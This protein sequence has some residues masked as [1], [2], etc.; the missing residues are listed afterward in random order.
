MLTSKETMGSS[1]QTTKSTATDRPLQWQEDPLKY[2][3]GQAED[4]YKQQSS[5]G[6]PDFNTYT[7]LNNVEYGA[8]NSTLGDSQKQAQT[9]S[10][11]TNLGSALAGS[12]ALSGAGLLGQY[13]SNAASGAAGNFQ[14]GTTAASDALLGGLGSTAGTT[15][16]S[17]T[18]A[19][20][21]ANTD[22]TQ[23]NATDAAAYANSSG[24]QNA[25]KD[26]LA[27]SDDLYQRTAVP[28]L[29]AAA[30]AGGNLNS[31]RAGA[32]QAI[33]DAMQEKN[34]QATASNM[35]NQ[36]FNQGLST[37]ESGRQANLQGLLG[38]SGQGNSALSLALQGQQAANDQTNTNNALQAT[39]NSQLGQAGSSLVG[40]AQTGSSLASDGMNMNTSANN[41][42]LSIG[43][44]LQSDKQSQKDAALNA[45][46]QGK[47]YDWDLLNNLYSIIG[48]QKWGGTQTSRQTVTATPSV[49]SMI[50]GAIGSLAGLGSSLGMGGAG[51][52]LGGLLKGAN[53]K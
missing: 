48:A 16:N 20:N 29:N 25:I 7:P 43:Q 14:Q 15:N 27:Q 11:L 40:A 32:A 28:S 52:L 38:T 33:S 8:I 21:L 18:S 36:A 2:A 4:L 37:A 35:W 53:N 46:L 1:H 9:G 51:G 23:Q 44:L 24:V 10:S 47:Q 30:I 34:D 12:T 42:A 3:F 17:L 50:Q 19:Y 39:Y 13:G 5:A 49:G 22:P 41:N 6:T 31:S 45:S 26:T